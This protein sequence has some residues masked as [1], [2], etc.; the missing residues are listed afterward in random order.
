MQRTTY[1]ML[2]IL[3]IYVYHLTTDIYIY[4]YIYVYDIWYITM[5]HGPAYNLCVEASWNEVASKSS[6]IRLLRGDPPLEQNNPRSVT[7]TRSVACL[8][9]SRPWNTALGTMGIFG[10]WWR[11]Y[12]QTLWCQMISGDF[13]LNNWYPLAMT[14]IA[15]GNQHVK[16]ENR[17]YM[18]NSHVKLPEGS[19][20]AFHWG[21]NHDSGLTSGND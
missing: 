13:T 1:S 17:P 20:M 4:I 16:R 12:H 6:N 5:L 10:M 7:G 9:R 8:S 2:C 3:R 11:V 15:M 18:F 21:F 19:F 14:N